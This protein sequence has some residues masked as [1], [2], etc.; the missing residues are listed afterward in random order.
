MPWSLFN[1]PSIQLGSLKAFVEEKSQHRVDCFHPFLHIAKAIGIETYRKISLDSWAGE[2]LF[3]SLLFTDQK[4]NAQQLFFPQTETQENIS[5]GDFD[6][7]QKTIAHACH[8]WIASIDFKQYQLIGFSV[9]FSQLLSS[10]YMAKELQKKIGNIPIVFGG[11]SCTGG[12]GT[13]LRDHFPEIDYVIDGEGEQPLLS[14]C[15]SIAKSSKK[16]IHTLPEEAEIKDINKLPYPNYSPYFN[17]IAALFPTEPFIPILPI[18]FSRGCWWNKCSFCNLNL[19]WE[20]YRSKT[21]DR[22]LAE[23]AHFVKKHECLNFTFTDNALPIKEAD[24]YFKA[25]G[26]QQ[27]DLDFFAEIRTINKPARLKL[28]RNGGLSTVQVG[29]EALS[30]SLLQKMVKGTTTITNVA[31]MKLCTESGI[32]IEGNLITEFPETT[33]EEINETLENLDFVLPYPPMATATFFL[34]YG[35]PIYEDHCKFGID[36]VSAHKNVKNLFP[37]KYHSTLKQ[38]VNDYSGDREFQKKLWQ[39]VRDKIAAWQ[40]FHNQ[41]ANNTSAPLSYRDSGTFIIIRQELLSGRP[42]HH[43]LKGLSRRIYLFCHTPK[44]IAEILDH[45]QGLKEEIL[46]SFV[47]ELCTKKIMFMEKNSVL[48]LALHQKN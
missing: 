14:L 18:E 21:A 25:V 4:D 12:L 24:S 10:I 43:R 6:Y 32:A 17:E 45:F 15:N 40:E 42:L 20:K 35:S 47:E 22:M 34:G 46:F 44:K 33:A 31:A 30:S 41:R 26:D 23:T 28:Y 9:C 13:S 48:S 3:S 5:P 27:I 7:L 39:P 11:S 8:T 1:R 37:D 38:L 16:T 19:Q 2:S 36:A 29:I